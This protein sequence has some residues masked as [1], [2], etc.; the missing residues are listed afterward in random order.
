VGPPL[1]ADVP[2]RP[3]RDVEAITAFLG[4]DPIVA[5]ADPT[6]PG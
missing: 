2:A 4:G 1:G 3:A 5:A 6:P